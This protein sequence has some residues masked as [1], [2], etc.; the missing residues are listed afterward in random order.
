MSLIRCDLHGPWDSDIYDHCPR[1]WESAGT[2]CQKYE[3]Q[4]LAVERFPLFEVERSFSWRSKDGGWS[5]AH[6]NVLVC[7]S[8]LRQWA[9]LQFAKDK[10]LWPIGA[11]C[12][13]CVPEDTRN[14][15]VPGSILFYHGYGCNID[16]ALLD[17]LP[18]PLLRREFD[19]HMKYL[20]RIDA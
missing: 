17:V 13:R 15:P 18:E 19:L 1:C 9:H 20:E 12:E 10:V 8:C 4:R 5:C 6:S 16:E 7:P 14:Y 2:R 11:Y 3:T